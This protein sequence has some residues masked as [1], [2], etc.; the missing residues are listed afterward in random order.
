MK[1]KILFTILALAV[2]GCSSPKPVAEVARNGAELEIRRYIFR[3]LSDQRPSPASIPEIST[4]VARDGSILVEVSSEATLAT[5]ALLTI[6]GIPLEKFRR[7]HQ[8]NRLVFVDPDH[9]PKTDHAFIFPAGGWPHWFSL[10]IDSTTG[11]VIDHHR[12][13]TM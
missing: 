1:I 12:P 7:E 11:K 2:A 13:S 5:P 3:H 6:G 4:T 8:G 9:F 10:M